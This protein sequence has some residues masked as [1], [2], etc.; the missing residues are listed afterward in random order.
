MKKTAIILSSILVLSIIALT[1]TPLDNNERGMKDLWEQ[2]TKA[3]NADKPQTQLE[4]LDRIIEGAASQPRSPWDFYEA[5]QK[6]VE[7]GTRLNWKMRSELL[8]AKEAAFDAFN[9]PVIEVVRG[10]MDFDAVKASEKV[11]KSSSNPGFYAEESFYRGARGADRYSGAL[12]R[13]LANDYDFALWYLLAHSD[14]GDREAVRKAIESR[15]GYPQ[16]AFADFDRVACRADGLGSNVARRAEYVAYEKKWSPSAASLLASEEIMSLKMDTLCSVSTS[17]SGEFRNLRAMCVEL[18]KR[19]KSYSGTEKIVADRCNVAQTLIL[20][21]DS[22]DI[23][24]YSDST[25]IIL[26][27]RNLDTARV[28]V[29][30]QNDGKLLWSGRATNNARSYYVIDTV[31]L[32]VPVKDDG[33]YV[34]TAV[35]GKEEARCNMRRH[36]IS[37]VATADGWGWTVFAAR[38]DSGEPLEKYDIDLYSNKKDIRIAGCTDFIQRDGLTL[39]PS[40]I[41]SAISENPGRSQYLVFSCRDSLG[42]LYS[43]EPVYIYPKEIVV[44]SAD[45]QAELRAVIFKDCGAYHRGDVMHCKTVLFTGEYYGNM[46]CAVKNTAALITFRDT[47]GNVVRQTKVKTNEYGSASADFTIPSDIRGG[48]VRIELSVG[49]RVLATSS[50]RVDDFVL[51]AFDCVFDKVEDLYFAGDTVTV[52]G[53]FVSYNGHRISI[54]RA[55]FEITGSEEK[56]KMSVA[57]DGSFEIEV[58]VPAN[59]WWGVSATVTA[60]SATGETL[61]FEKALNVTRHLDLRVSLENETP[62]SVEA[63]S[64]GAFMA[65]DPDV[66][67]FS[68]VL[69]DSVAVFRTEAFNGDGT[70]QNLD[71]RWTL[72]RGG[73]MVREGH[74]RTPDSLSLRLPASAGDYSVLFVAS[75]VDSRGERIIRKIRYDIIRVCPGSTVLDADVENLFIA[76]EEEGIAFEAGAARGPVWAVATLYGFESKPLYSK[77]IHL[78]GVRACEGSMTKVSLPYLQEYPDAV[79]MSVFYFRNG[80]LY[81]WNHEYRR[82]LKEEDLELTWSRFV[83]KAVPGAEYSFTLR[84]DR[85]SEVLVSVFDKSTERICSNGWGRVYGRVPSAVLPY[86]CYACGS[87]GGMQ[88]LLTKNDGI[89]VAKAAVLAAGTDDGFRMTADSAVAAQEEAADSGD[90]V[91]IRSDFATSICWQPFLRTSSSGTASFKFRTSDRTGTFIVSAFAHDRAMRNAAERREMVVSLPLEITVAEPAVLR[92]G[93]VYVLKATLSAT[94]DVSGD[95]TLDAGALGKFQRS[96]SLKAD[97]VAVVTYPLTLPSDVDSVK[98]TLVFRDRNRRFSDAVALAVPVGPAVQTLTEAHS[99]V[100]RNYDDKDAVVALL[101]S[102]FVNTSSYGA[103]YTEKSLSAMVRETLAPRR[104]VAGKSITDLTDAIGVNMLY[105]HI[106]GEHTDISAML[107]L[108]GD[109]SNDDGGYAWMEGMQ[110]SPAMTSS[111]LERCA[112][113]AATTGRSFLDHDRKAAAVRYLDREAFSDRWNYNRYVFWCPGISLAQYLYVRSLFADVPFETQI[114]DGMKDDFC[115]KA[116][117]YLFPEDVR[118]LNGHVFAKVLRLSTLDN[119]YSSKEGEALLK[120]LGIAPKTGVRAVLQSLLADVESLKEYTVEHPSGGRYCPNLVM[121]YRG[122]LA[123]EAYCHSLLCDLLGHYAPDIADGMRLWLMVQKESQKWDTNF[124]FTNAVASVLD[125]SPE[126]LAT[127]VLV[128]SKTYEKPYKEIKAAGNGFSVE[129]RFEITA[130]GSAVNGKASLG[131]DSRTV[132]SAGDTLHAGDRITAVYRIRSDENRSYVRLVV[133]AYGCL[134]P[135]NQLSGT[136]YWRQNPLYIG[137]WGMIPQGYREVRSDAS[138][139]YFESFPEEVTEIREEYFVTQTG[140]FTAPVVEVES[141]YAPYYRANGPFEGPLSVE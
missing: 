135:V 74:V 59:R 26:C 118:G 13:T 139:Y 77:M 67:V 114:P 31:R 25:S 93:D 99:A 75:A 18:E 55:F 140:V 58:P 125:A 141:L 134:R 121:P 136:M 85:P 128:M 82:P 5:W 27:L 57:P 113:V 44:A 104:G 53:R 65:Y 10:K 54:T 52:K 108:L 83:D 60:S 19:R 126:V 138:A 56:R 38:H 116:G 111:V 133:P 115:A 110:S 117:A 9:E 84:T 78:A 63:G 43:S 79:N 17:T 70:A 69:S 102:Q 87:L 68:T 86:L 16:K 61:E 51:P 24:L 90:D 39:L 89:M 46:A 45:G 100:C 66:D 80:R 120:A 137:G 73:D 7:V 30:G 21:L 22:R 71:V 14:G 33:D 91:R 72:Y 129:R 42:N 20:R 107:A 97:S 29:T 123:D 132:L 47:E 50:A 49:D 105:D 6:K 36:H 130:A 11:L 98:M 131:D 76:R 106:T 95:F 112:R 81:R 88:P 8:P 12:A 48:V 127:S 15:T 94:D 37:A 41:T 32:P 101:R 62:A 35:S 3:E 124:A 64:D 122:L 92:A 28:A 96:I 2:Y 1:G 34:L 40:D 103:E 119:I 23:S 109:Y 4:I